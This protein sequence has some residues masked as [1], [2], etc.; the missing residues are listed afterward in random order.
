MEVDVDAGWLEKRIQ[1][2]VTE[3]LNDAHCINNLQLILDVKKAIHKRSRPFVAGVEV[4]YQSVKSFSF[5]YV[6]ATP[7]EAKSQVFRDV[8]VAVYQIN[9]GF[10]YLE[11]SEGRYVEAAFNIFGEEDSFD[12]PVKTEGT[13]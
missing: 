3:E 2:C 1:E 7:R 11:D 10:D 5:E 13:A 8:A 4:I 12:R 6:N 9:D